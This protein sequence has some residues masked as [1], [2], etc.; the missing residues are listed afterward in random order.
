M[1]RILENLNKEINVKVNDQD[2][3][4]S[5]LLKYIKDIAQ[6]GHTFD[7]IV[8]PGNKDYEK[9]FEIDGDGNFKIGDIEETKTEEESIKTEASYTSST[10]DSLTKFY[11]AA[12]KLSEDWNDAFD[13]EDYPFKLSFDELVLEIEKWYDTSKKKYDE[14]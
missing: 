14:K 13:N 6:S 9:S 4:L 7:V 5:E 1:I 8:D 10:I 12:K 2:N 3:Q 11:Y